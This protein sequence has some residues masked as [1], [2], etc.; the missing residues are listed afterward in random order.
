MRLILL[1]L[2]LIIAAPA[3][4][5]PEPYRLDREN[6]F[7]GFGYTFSGNPARGTMPVVAA[8][9]MLD[10]DNP[11]RSQVAAT[12]DPARAS[13]G[14]FLATSAMKGPQVL[15]TR[16]FP[17]ITF[18]STRVIPDG[19]TARIEG[20]ITIKGITRPITLDAQL[21]RQQGTDPGERDRLSMRLKGA[22]SR[23]AFGA[24]GF[25]DLVGDT[26]TLDIVARV[27]RVR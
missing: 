8:R 22:I 18:Q 16:R 14:L 26:I 19:W 21:F 10:L 9:I 3:L 13:A 27:D 4:A 7:V 23:A 1:I 2:A 15:D 11:A 25:P 5:D 17:R 12:L 6:S 20:K 24:G